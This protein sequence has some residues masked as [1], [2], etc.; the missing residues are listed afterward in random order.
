MIGIRVGKYRIV[1]QLGRGAT[2]IVY[3]AVDETLDREV[4]I[5]VLHP[6]LADSEMMKRFRAEATILARLSHPE[7]ATIYELLPAE[8]NLLMVMELVRGETLEELCAGVGPMPPDRAACL[9]D[10]MLSALAHA[11]H[12]GIV[13][14]DMK[15]A[16]VMVTESGGVK[17]MDF[18]IARIRGGEHMTLDGCAIG[19]PA[20]MAPEQ[21]LGE[22][23][24][25]RADLY[26]VG[27]IF[28]R[29]LAGKLPFDADTPMAILQQQ[30]AETPPPLCVHREALPEWCDAIVQR[31]LAKAAGDRFQS[32][33]EFRAALAQAAGTVGSVVPAG[34]LT[35][36]H[37]RDRAV[38]QDAP[39]C[40][41][42]AVPRAAAEG[43]APSAEPP[44]VTKGE[45]LLRRGKD[46]ARAREGLLLA[47]FI[48]SG[49]LGYL[50]L[51]RSP[52]RPVTSI[53]ADALPAVAF[54]ARVLVSTAARQ[55]EREVRVLLADGRVRVMADDGSATPLHEVPYGNV[56][57]ISYSR[58]RDPMWK[59]PKGAA[60]VVRSTGGTLG[61]LGIF[62][63]RHW[64][65]LQTDGDP[66]FIVLRVDEGLARRM[67]TALEERTG[68]TPAT[69]GR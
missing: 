52:F 4:A 7:I 61:K 18:G 49:G 64:V 46:W 15:P 51:D 29:L 33:E 9:T 21:V 27:V 69:V 38:L 34:P 48:V 56:R 40:E 19:T 59:S 35:L 67:L 39:P 3:K 12:A 60:A 37:A 11:H 10:R 44:V 16:N 1:A 68:R 47:L 55:R 58:G 36:P 57:S 8:T 14:R 20:Y 62:V 24:D 41:T 63:D 53:A 28:Y 66:Q 17:I 31:A 65:S 25:G 13:H 30:M 2:G 54:K 26:S 42:V 45:M 50:A 22:E 5:K 43:E 23:V 32:A 6:A